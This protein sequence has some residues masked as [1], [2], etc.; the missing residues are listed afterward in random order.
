[1]FGFWFLLG[2]LFLVTVFGF[3]LFL[4]M[5]FRRSWISWGLFAA[6]SVWLFARIGFELSIPE[7]ILYAVSLAGALAATWMTTFLRKSGYA[8]FSK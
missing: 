5:L 1:M 2:V 6:A 4:N 3:G 8:L 7:W